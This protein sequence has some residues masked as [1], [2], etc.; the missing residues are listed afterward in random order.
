M[1][2]P[3]PLLIR[4]LPE[5]SATDA[6]VHWPHLA[7]AAL[8]LALAEQ[9]ADS[10]GPLV[11]LLPDARASDALAAALAFFAPEE[12]PVFSIPER[13]ML[14][15]DIVSPARALISERLRAL[16][17]LPTLTQGIVLAT[18]DLALERLSPRNWLA[19]ASFDYAVGQ[20]LDLEAF[21]AEL[22]AA[23]YAAVGEVRE[24]GE[25]ALRGGL[26]DVFPSG[27]ETPVRMDLFDDAIETLRHFDPDTQLSDA[28]LERIALLPAWEF[29]F[30]AEGIKQFRQ[31][32]RARF[33][34]DPMTSEIY[35]AI[36]EERVPPGIESW[37]PLFFEA[38]DGLADYLPQS[39]TLVE[40]PGFDAALD[41]TRTQIETRFESARHD[42]TR[43]LLTPDETFLAPA[44]LRKAFTSHPRILIATEAAFQIQ[45]PSPS[46]GEVALSSPSPST[47]EAALS[48][49][50]PLTG[51]GWGEGDKQET[52]SSIAALPELA[53]EPARD[54]PLARFMEFAGG[55]SSL[56]LAAESPGR[57]ETV[58]E[59]LARRGLEPELIE[60]W[61]D[62][63]NRRPRLALAVAELDD[64]FALSAANLAVVPDSAVFG[65]RVAATRRR[66]R[67]A[68]DPASIIRDLTDLIVG[69]PVVHQDHGVGRF[70]GLVT[71]EVD[72]NA[73]EFVL[74]EYAGGDKL[75]VPV[76]SLDR[77]SRYLG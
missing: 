62:F 37:L 63:L 13:E 75:Y 60:S 53:L 77:L 3:E 22:V 9:A 43:P 66:K 39:A 8:A 45:S 46:T 55:S 57:R 33:A 44:A 61:R 71:R 2:A 58:R 48:S 11:V 59:V 65:T 6:P 21:R 27:A 23:G 12:L 76:A 19:A 38:T 5:P 29:P 10:P 72:G 7:G 24:P 56:L 51:E 26:I 50:S 25:F 34:G 20:R 4:G 35:R 68:R 32:W 16:A 54:E 73:I 49:P 41:A 31:A 30:N 47:E 18:A 74:L 42:I 28:R 40:L 52:V 14:P 70:Q 15:Y 64:G 17:R 36:S 1:T 67:A 69:A